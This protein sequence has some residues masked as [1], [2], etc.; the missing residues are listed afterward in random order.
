MPVAYV[1]FAYVALLELQSQPPPTVKPRCAAT[2][3]MH[4]S[5]PELATSY[6]KLFL[7]PLPMLTDVR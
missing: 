3:V 1:I 6:W 4:S 5:F 7:R 2:T